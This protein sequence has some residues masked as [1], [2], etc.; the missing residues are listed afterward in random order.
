MI[1][2]L[3]VYTPK[4]ETI[5]YKNKNLQLN[6][7]VQISPSTYL[8]VKPIIFIVMADEWLT[9]EDFHMVSPE[10]NIKLLY[11]VTN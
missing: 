11:L 6:H 7:K 4:I 3:I 2:V 10:P 1:S 8:R 5:N 9:N